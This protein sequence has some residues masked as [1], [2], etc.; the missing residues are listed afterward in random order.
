MNIPFF[1]LF[2][3][4]IFIDRAFFLH[5]EPF[6]RTNFDYAWKKNILYPKIIL[7][8]LAKQFFDF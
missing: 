4:R 5:S 3:V 6:G 2:N 8:C 7:K 1:P